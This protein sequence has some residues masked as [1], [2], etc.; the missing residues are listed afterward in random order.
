MTTEAV[1]TKRVARSGTGLLVWVPKD[2]AVLLQLS[3]ADI[4]QI[5]MRRLSRGDGQS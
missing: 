1:F 3:K 2:I 4:V 5:R